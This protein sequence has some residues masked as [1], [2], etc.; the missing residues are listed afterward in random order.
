MSLLDDMTKMQPMISGLS[1][2]IGQIGEQ[3]RA[4][5]VADKTK[6]VIDSAMQEAQDM[7]GGSDTILSVMNDPMKFYPV[8]TK[9]IAQ[10]QS[11]NPEAAKNF[12]T[13]FQGIAGDTLKNKQLGIEQQNADANST[14]AKIHKDQFD[15]MNVKVGDIPGFAKDG[16]VMLKINDQNV[17][18]SGF[19]LSQLN[20]LKPLLDKDTQEKLAIYYGKKQQ[21]TRIANYNGNLG[22]AWQ[23]ALKQNTTLSMVSKDID[24]KEAIENAGRGLLDN[25][26]SSF[27]SEAKKVSSLIAKKHNLNK[28][29]QDGLANELA[30]FWQ[31]TQSADP[32]TMARTE[33]S[34]AN[35]LSAN[36]RSTY[37]ANV[38]AYSSSMESYNMPF[39]EY[40]IKKGF[41]PQEADKYNQV[42][43][44]EQA[45]GDALGSQMDGY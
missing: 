35:A 3:R 32:N 18:V 28:A 4:R 40:L 5:M 26:K 2:S 16:K 21:E 25:P 9:T 43:K 29:Q 39:N 1:Q 17:D 44:E 12:G 20:V 24:T 31:S 22:R 27:L 8:A 36:E 10:L 30:N 37:S 11:F 15:T 7:S 33:T 23:E 13:W 38:K 34:R 42:Y 41:T 45:K 19:T 14:E 6:E